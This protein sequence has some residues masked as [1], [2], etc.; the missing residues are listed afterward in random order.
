M[1]K[2]EY[3]LDSL[4]LL[5]PKQYST[6]FFNVKTAKNNKDINRFAFVVSKKI[7]KRATERNELKRKVRSSFEEIFDRISVGNDFIIYPKKEA[8]KNSWSDILNDVQN[9]LKKNNLLK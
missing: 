7:D 5:N 8:A 6:L 4:R 9:F 3:R 1:L 2:K